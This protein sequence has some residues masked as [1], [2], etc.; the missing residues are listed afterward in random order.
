MFDRNE[1]I[2]D[3]LDIHFQFIQGDHIL[4]HLPL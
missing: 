4:S 1:I 2:P 3:V